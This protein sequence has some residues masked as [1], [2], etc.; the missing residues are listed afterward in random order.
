MQVIGLSV[1]VYYYDIIENFI[2]L[3]LLHLVFCNQSLYYTRTMQLI[4][5]LPSN[6]SLNGISYNSFSLKFQIC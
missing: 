5:K 1:A 2:V 3:F 6:R 4:V